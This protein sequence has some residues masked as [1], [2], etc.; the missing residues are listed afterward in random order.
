MCINWGPSFVMIYNDGYLEALGTKHPVL[1]RQLP[2][3]FAE[4]WGEIADRH[5]SVL[6]GAET[7][8]EEDV[9]FVIER[10]AGPEERYYT[11]SWSHVDSDNSADGPGGVLTVLTSRTREVVGARRLH[12]LNELT[13]RAPGQ[14]DPGAAISTCLE[15]L[16]GAT[17]E[18]VAV[19]FY[20]A[21][22]LDG[23]PTGRVPQVVLDCLRHAEVTEAATEGKTLVA[24]LVRA[25][26]RVAGVLLLAPHPLRPLDQ[27]HRLWLGLVA[28]QVGQ[29]LTLATSRADEQSR[30]TALADIDAAKSD[31][32]SNVSHEFRTPLTLMLGPL[33]DALATSEPRLSRAQV[34]VMHRSGRRLLRLVDALMDVA[35][36][37]V[38]PREAVIEPVD[39]TAL[40]RDVALP[41][42]LA[43]S[44][45]GL[46]LT[47]S[48]E[49]T[50]VIGSD[51][52]L[53]ETILTNLAA[54]A[55]KY[56]REGRVELGLALDGD[57]AELRVSDSG[58]GIPE[59]HHQR[60]FERF[61]RVLGPEAVTV[62]GTGLGLALV[63]EAVR[64]LDGTID[65]ASQ[66]GA[67][68]VFTVRA[69]LLARSAGPKPISRSTVAAQM[70]A[71]DVTPIPPAPSPAPVENTADEAATILVVDDNQAMRERVAHVLAPLGHLV[72]C[73]DGVAAL[74][75]LE[76]QRFDLVVTDVSMPRLDGL[77]LVERL[78]ADERHAAVPVVVLSARAGTEA[79]TSALA[80]GADDYVVKPFTSADLLA[81]CR[82]ILA[83]TRLRA[84]RS[85]SAARD[86]VLAGVS[87]E[88]QT[89]LSVVMS[90][91][92]LLAMP[93]TDEA[94]RVE[95]ARRA[96][97]RIRA[98][99][100][101]VRQFLDWSR[102]T[103]GLPIVTLR[104]PVALD[105]LLT[106]VVAEHPRA[107]LEDVS[108]VREQP[109]SCDLRRTEQI[110]HTL[111]NNALRTPDSRVEVEVA[112]YLD[113]DGAVAGYDVLVRDDGPGLDE[114]VLRGLLT[115]LAL[116]GTPGTGAIGLAVSRAAARAQGG[117]LTIGSTD[118][119]GSVFVL[120]LAAGA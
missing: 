89:P 4:I 83:L 84:D 28:E 6:D 12:L 55:I 44:Q 24:V 87:H 16:R 120:R 29:V 117:D 91:L 46:L 63:G 76:S 77:G 107:S 11:F 61:H 56:T 5:D 114:Q 25:R 52:V 108:V 54:N 112:E 27:D 94:L 119:H 37:E 33:E 104:T 70:L 65:L 85:S 45:S 75:A 3:V 60:V 48:F 14:D 102:I 79:A 81:R 68:S 67:G 42:E 106:L 98:L 2:E 64:A 113:P 99:D 73:G 82:S 41:F 116:S 22:A 100:R 69:P 13:S 111:V 21:D 80:L 18:L 40:L 115:P 118:Q 50:G 78:R 109:V 86:E 51:A 95:A 1:A 32:L 9:P 62:E 71:E 96:A 105:D 92:D 19:D 35:R 15:V 93:D 53:W 36:M 8:Y 23:V 31:F 103:T 101:L 47:T 58:I 39:L 30:L 90:A 38:D 88:M 26:D 66:P 20:A 74:E 7:V 110:L 10:G 97:A 17:S 43:A 49:E 72:T 34:Q 57:V 59:S